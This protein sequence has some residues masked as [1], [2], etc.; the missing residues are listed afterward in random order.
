VEVQND[1]IDLRDVV[2]VIRNRWK[3][4]ILPAVVASLLV[5]IV[6]KS[7]PKQYESYALIKIG[8]VGNKEIESVASI[9]EIM[10]SLAIR[11]EIAAK[12]RIDN[13]DYVNALEGMLKYKNSSELLEIRS[14]GRTPAQSHEL[15]Q[16]ATGIVLNRHSMLFG[17]AKKDIDQ[18]LRY[19][20]QTVNPMPLSIGIN[21]IRM[22]PTR[23]EVPPVV[24]SEPKQGK[25]EITI[26]AILLVV[27][28]LDM[29]IAFYNEGKEK[30]Q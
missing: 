9:T 7:M 16:A 30:K 4:I 2:R 3:L 22:E 5:G 15:A 28:L 11:K 21:D 19:V 1:E 26:I 18:T 6:M 27:M 12:M 29:F 25:T 13:A 24:N 10:N 14:N 23:I 8:H 20:K 17:N